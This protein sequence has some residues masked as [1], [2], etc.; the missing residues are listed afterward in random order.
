MPKINQDTQYTVNQYRTLYLPDG[1]RKVV[2]Y[3]HDTYI[4]LVLFCIT[5]E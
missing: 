1:T 3:I 4:M 5:T 2:T